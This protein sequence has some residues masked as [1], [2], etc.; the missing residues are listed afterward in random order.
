MAFYNLDIADPDPFFES[1]V[2]GHSCLDTFG[3]WVTTAHVKSDHGH[4]KDKGKNSKK[5]KKVHHPKKKTPKPLHHGLG[6]LRY[7]RVESLYDGMIQYNPCF[8]EGFILGLGY[9]HTELNWNRIRYFDKINYNNAIFSIGCFTYRMQ[10]WRWLFQVNLNM[11]ADKWKFGQYSTYDYLVWGRY[12]YNCRLGFH[13][14]V[15]AETGL[16]LGRV[17]PVLGFDW[18]IREN[19]KLNAVFPFNA[20]LIYTVD[21]HLSLIIGG[22]FFTDR[23]RAPRHEKFDPG[24]DIDPAVVPKRKEHGHEHINNPAWR[25]TNIGIE[26]GLLHNQC[27]WMIAEGHVG[28][29]VYGRLKVIHHRRDLPSNLHIMPAVYFGGSLTLRF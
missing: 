14:G 17:F 6:H 9:G 27:D 2:D 13:F 15:Y 22:R 4:K 11:D 7:N 21:Q 24:I 23:Q 5:H 20:S 25:Y 18:Q 8:H 12:E 29:T 19:W 3:E 10:N 26:F 28:Y 16:E 1:G